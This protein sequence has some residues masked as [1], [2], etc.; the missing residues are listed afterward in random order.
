M[1]NTIQIL[2]IVITLAI[3]SLVN[4]QSPYDPCECSQRMEKSIVYGGSNI[5]SHQGVKYVFYA[6]YKPEKYSCAKININESS[7]ITEE[8]F[9]KVLEKNSTYQML[10]RAGKVWNKGL[11]GKIY[12][13]AT[14]VSEIEEK[15]KKEAM[16]YATP[17]TTLKAIK[18]DVDY[19]SYF[20]KFPTCKN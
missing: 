1:K 5:V 19:Q 11:V 10:L 15:V 13:E 16:Q 17:N 8:A 9:E 2:T 3:T 14:S 12:F 7:N 20:K 6:Y 18:L 4:A